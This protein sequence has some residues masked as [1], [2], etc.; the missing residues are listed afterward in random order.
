MT[1]EQRAAFERDGYL[2]PLQMC[3]PAEMAHLRARIEAAVAARPGPH[4][5][6]IWSSRHQDCR[7][8]Y[9]LCANERIRDA[10][11][12]VL[13]P[14]LVVWNSVFMAKEPGAGEVPWHQDRDYLMLEPDISLAVWLAIDD[15]T[16]A[17]G[18]L[19]LLPGSHR[20]R[21]A[22]TPR[23][24]PD[25]FDASVSDDTATRRASVPI[26]LRAGE[27]LLFCNRILH[28][29]APN[30]STRRRLGL[31]IRFTVP[32]VRVRTDQLFPGH[33]VYPV[34]GT[35]RSERNPVGQPPLT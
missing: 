24:R 15:A 9:E 34:R 13:G 7:V 18:C 33:R 8:V 16:T 22:H 17:N 10:V 19:D 21:L 11:A 1:P 23:Q 12:Q 20:E 6:D 5:G 31:A 30:R 25:E 32:S 3:S 35:H 26:E 4:G 27:F 14:D 29:S 28:H 2:A